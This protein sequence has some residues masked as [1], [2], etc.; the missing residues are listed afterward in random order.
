MM[1]RISCALVALLLAFGSFSQQSAKQKVNGWHLLDPQ[2][3]GY[4]GISLN[5]AYELLKGRKATTVLV[6]VIDSGVDTLHED[7]QG[8]LWR[9]EKEVPGNG[10]DDDGNGY[11]DDVYGWNFCGSREGENLIHDTREIAR[12]FHGW[13]TE[14][15]GKKKKNVPQDRQFFFEQWTKAA[16]LVNSYYTIGDVGVR[17]TEPTVLMVKAHSDVVCKALNTKEFTLRELSPLLDHQDPKVARSASYWI[18]LMSRQ[19]DTTSSNTQVLAKLTEF[20]LQLKDMTRYKNETLVN[21]RGALIQDNYTDINDRCYGNNNLKTGSGDQGTAVTGVI[22]ALRGNG[23]SA[24]GITENARIMVVR[25]VPEEGDE[26]DKDVALAIRYAVDNGAQIINMSFGKPVSPYKQFVDDAVRYAASKGVLLVHAAGGGSKEVLGEDFYP[27]AYFLDG[28]RAWNFLSVGASDDGT[29]QNYVAPRSRFGSKWVDIFAP[30]MAIHSTATD[31]RYTTN[32]GTSV[33][34]PVVTGVAAL[35][36]SY[37][38]SLTPQD[39]IRIITAS[40]TKLD[41]EVTVPGETKKKVNFSELSSSGR[42]VNAGNA[43]KMALAEEGK[44]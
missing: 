4:M 17:T 23:N 37:F 36:K 33:A 31:N 44:K 16:Y 22:G 40:G 26:H 1:K 3:D 21:P 32:D 41:K 42:I 9:N 43:V 19:E 11:P 30:G 12:V 2:K 14:F 24:N 39:I 8:I 15:E 38:P 7:L 25:V 27:D 13:R 20:L 5:E 29:E 28:T 18:G 35:L 10:K 6:A 34:A